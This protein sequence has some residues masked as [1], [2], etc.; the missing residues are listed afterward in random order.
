MYLIKKMKLN[1]NIKLQQPKQLF[2]HFQLFVLDILPLKLPLWLFIFMLI[3]LSNINV[4]TVQDFRLNQENIQKNW[5]RGEGKK[6]K[7]KNTLMIV[8]PRGDI[9][10]NANLVEWQVVI[11]AVNHLGLKKGSKPVWAVCLCVASAK[12]M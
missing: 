3:I 2:S 9:S 1:K 6:N 5:L 4:Y 7:K 8:I 12:R 10:Q 11:A